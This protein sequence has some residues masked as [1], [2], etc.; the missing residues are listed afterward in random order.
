ML[1]YIGSYKEMTEREAQFLG[2]PKMSPQRL[3]LGSRKSH[4]QNCTFLTVRL[5]SHFSRV[6]LCVTP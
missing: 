5:I 2:L 6:R 4:P 1:L 3:V